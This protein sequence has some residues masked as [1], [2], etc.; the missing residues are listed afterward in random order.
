MRRPSCIQA[1][2]PIAL[3]LFFGL[4]VSPGQA[5]D[6]PAAKSTVAAATAS[7]PHA[8]ESVEDSLQA[9]MARIP[10]D[11]TAGQRMIAEQSCLR[12]EGDRKPF[13]ATGGR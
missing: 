5:A 3:F 6:K 10:K 1:L 12:D 4:Q 11:A 9:C 13:Q 7:S 8:A 2:T